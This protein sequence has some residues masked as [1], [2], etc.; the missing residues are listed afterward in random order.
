MSVKNTYVLTET[1]LIRVVKLELCCLKQGKKMINF[2]LKQG[3][4]LMG[5]AAHH[6]GKTL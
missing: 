5:S 2:C 1:K 6:G 3:E 4:S